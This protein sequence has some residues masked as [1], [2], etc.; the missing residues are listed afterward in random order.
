MY[1]D[2]VKEVS[3]N[4]YHSIM[5]GLDVKH[6]LDTGAVIFHEGVHALMGAVV[7]FSDMSGRFGLIA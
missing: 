4:E 6:V 5:E 7:I 2:K 3:M 1:A